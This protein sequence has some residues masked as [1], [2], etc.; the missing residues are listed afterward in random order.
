MSDEMIKALHDTVAT[1]EALGHEVFEQG[2]G[3]DYRLLYRSQSLVS[4]S[5]FSATIQ[6]WIDQLGRQPKESE[7]GALAQRGWE[8]GLKITGQQALWGW[9]QLRLI[10]RQILNRFET[11]DVFLTPTMSTTSPRLD[12]LDPIT[13]PIKEFDRRQAE[14]YGTT[15]PFN[16]T[17][18]PSLS[19]PLWQS[20]EGLPMGMMFTGRFADEATLFKLAGQLEKELPWSDRRPAIWN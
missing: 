17:G 11:F 20:A 3:I 10:N 19:L 5:N 16:F 12:W 14:T 1:L 15:P 7:L 9:Q 8:A 13:V 18:Q 2:L 4:A 6:R